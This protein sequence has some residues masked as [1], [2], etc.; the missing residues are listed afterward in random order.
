MDQDEESA[1]E[2]PRKIGAAISLPT[3]EGGSYA[4]GRN[5]EALGEN[6]T[7]PKHARAQPPQQILRAP[8]NGRKNSSNDD[9]V[10]PTALKG[11]YTPP[12]S[13]Q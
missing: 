10:S 7:M 9:V 2:P 12:L 1:L 4:R 8:D 11:S 3:G 6:S 13:F 5:I